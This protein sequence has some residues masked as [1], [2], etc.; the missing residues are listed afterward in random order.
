MKVA[1]ISHSYLEPENQK[2]MI[3]LNTLCDV[4]CILPRR[5]PVLIFHNYEFKNRRDISGVFFAYRPCYLAK[6][7]Y[8]L[9]SLTMGLHGFKP[10]VIN[11]EYNPWSLIFFQTLLYRNIYSRKSKIV[12]TLKKNTYRCGSGIFGK[13]KDWVAR[14]SLK[15]VDHI[16]A[17]SNMVAALCK[18]E[19]SIPARKVSVCHHL[20]VDVS[21][22][23]PIDAKY[24]RDDDAAPPIVVGYCGRL[25]ADKGIQDLIEAM[26]LVKRST[27]RAVVLKLMGCGAYGDFLDEHLRN[28][29]QEADWLELLPPVPNAEVANFLR[30]LDIFVLPSRIL[31]DHQEHDAHVLLEA[32]ACGVPCIGT[33][34]GIIPEILGNGVGCLVSPQNPHALCEALS[35]L[36]GNPSERGILAKRGRTKSVE[37]FSLSV[38][39]EKKYNIFRGVV[40]ESI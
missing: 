19:F 7:Q 40:N 39:A 36:I 38:V 25:D 14:F 18:S 35:F 20:G 16:F 2:N 13:I 8:I 1:I 29:S 21:L 6:A 4:R 27:K 26:R 37:E 5:G 33:K 31:D 24:P 10:D 12:C 28:E 9:S 15:R 32:M 11:I 3:A 23:S 30:T 17:A 34:S 22:F